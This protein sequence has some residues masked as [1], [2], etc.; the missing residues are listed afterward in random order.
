MNFEN[1]IAEKLFDVA[2]E[3]AVN[4]FDYIRDYIKT[5]VLSGDEKLKQRASSLNSHKAK[6][7]KGFF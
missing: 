7:N 2:N 3:I 4:Q 6:Y 5:Y 1:I